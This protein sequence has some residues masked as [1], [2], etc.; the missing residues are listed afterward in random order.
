MTPHLIN[1]CI[2]SCV[3]MDSNEEKM[4]EETH[5]KYEI[6]MQTSLIKIIS[7]AL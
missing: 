4:D 2:I 7:H 5:F 1:K 3:Q 6:I